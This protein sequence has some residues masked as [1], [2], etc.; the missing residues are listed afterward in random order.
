MKD[1]DLTKTLKKYKSGWVAID[2]QKRKVI[3]QAK[4]FDAITKKVGKDDTIFVM[5]A[6]EEYFGFIT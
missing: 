6:S 1:L 4:D 5:P 3:A 2:E